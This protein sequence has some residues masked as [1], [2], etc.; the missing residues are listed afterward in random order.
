MRL[1]MIKK[2][3]FFS[4]F[5]LQ[6]LSDLN[7]HMRTVHGTYRRR[8]KIPREQL[9]GDKMEDQLT[10][11]DDDSTEDWL[12]DEQ[13][14]EPDKQ[15]QEQPPSLPRIV[16][17][18]GSIVPPVNSLASS[19]RFLLVQQAPPVPVVSLP[20]VSNGANLVQNGAVSLIVPS[21]P[22]VQLTSEADAKLVRL[23]NAAIQ[24]VKA[25]CAA[26]SGQDDQLVNNIKNELGLSSGITLQKISK[27]SPPT[28]AANAPK[29]HQL[30]SAPLSQ[31]AAAGGS[32]SI[33]KQLPKL[34]YHGPRLQ[35]H[36][37]P[38]NGST[39]TFGSISLTP[40][41]SGGKQGARMP[42]VKI[43][44]PQV[45]ITSSGGSLHNIKPGLPPLIPISK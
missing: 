3:V 22:A 38:E 12:T 43:I 14:A 17:A 25:S 5:L 31:A 4:D 45:E 15:Q 24:R 35:T 41:R 44:E 23:N 33:V 10:G 1:N 18:V 13:A 8:T 6:V 36:S 21:L 26:N 11:G 28:V 19:G 40:I 2:I 29:L 30:L 34:S 9:T 7:K 27:P 37:P 39:T 20:L 42:R 32:P 16:S